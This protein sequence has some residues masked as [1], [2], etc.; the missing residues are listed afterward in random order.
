MPNTFEILSPDASPIFLAN[1]PNERGGRIHHEFVRS[2]D[3]LNKFLT[4]YNHPGRAL[5]WTVSR[6]AI[7]EG[8]LIGVDG[9]WRCK[10]NV[11]DTYLIWAEVDFK[12][13]PDIPPEEIK[14][15]IMEEVRPK[16]SA[17]VFSG[18]GL[19]VYW[20]LREREDASP[21]EGQRRVEEALTLACQH[22][23][24]DPH[25][26]EVARLMRL[27]GSRNTRIPGESL[28]VTF[29]AVEQH[30]YSLEELENVWLEAAPILPAP[31]K[32]EGARTSGRAPAWEGPLETDGE[33]AAMRVHSADA[34]IHCTQLRISAKLIS[35]GKLIT[36][37]VGRILTA[38]KKAVEGV[39][40]AA[41]WDWVMEEKDIT[42]MC[43][44]WINKRMKEDGEDLS[45]CLPDKLY[46]SWQRIR[47]TDARPF[48]T[49]NRF[50]ALVRSSSW[51][52]KP[53]SAGAAAADG[54]SPQG[55][56]G[57]E[58][59]TANVR[60]DPR[61]LRFRIVSFGDMRPGVEP[62]YL[63]DELVPVRG[64]VDIWGK[65]KC[66]KSFVVLDM[67]L[68]VAMGWE[69]H[70]RSVRQGAVVYCAFEGA[71]GYKKRVEA[72]RRHYE[73]AE[74][75]HVPLY[76]M[77]G[78]ANLI[79]DHVKLIADL[80]AQLGDVVPVAV[81]LD[82]LNKSLIGSES[83]DLDMS[84]YLRAAEAIRD[85]FGC[86]VIIV[87]HCGLDETRPRGHTSLPGAVDAQIAVV[88]EGNA[89]TVT[90]EH[91]RDGPE[92]TFVTCVAKSVDVGVD[93]NGKI[94]NSLVMVPGEALTNARAPRKWTK[95]LAVFRKAL[96]EALLSSD[97]TVN[98]NGPIRAADAEAVRTAFYAI[99]VAKGE[100]KVQQ[101]DNR[102]QAFHRVVDKA[103]KENLI[104]VQVLPNGQTLLWLA[105]PDTTDFEYNLQREPS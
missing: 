43:F 10:G 67:M 63:I 51:E 92:E 75:T 101:Q 8:S 30:T 61:D 24:G 91:M 39:E 96:S 28:P 9:S 86:V 80:K 89:V 19:H 79:K 5:Y 72:L 53:K 58:E 38:T 93:A 98:I 23:G 64:L 46:D 74:D 4:R 88:R 104:G 103:Q 83:K 29:E 1:L 65:P 100:T 33:L 99:Y 105:T 41:S 37:V 81:V 56:V 34:P 52:P 57:R 40:E 76:I 90:V 14:R 25:V 68:H 13:H 62:L 94:L 49:F 95:S 78:Q 11:L 73:I 35:E 18:H 15:R 66:F 50:G 42:R 12:D 20:R 60:N 6:L 71:H 44:D 16:P 85:A 7:P 26:A 97:L 102:R 2:E 70:D 47:Q 45:H 3:E 32:E 59:A 36:D 82:T 27:P 87:H 17:I 55:S 22:V 84:A 77:P 54:E 69:Y 21:G 48:I 31:K